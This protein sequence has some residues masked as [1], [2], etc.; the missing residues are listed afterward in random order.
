MQLYGTMF[1]IIMSSCSAEL[2]K[3]CAAIN[4][5]NSSYYQRFESFLQRIFANLPESHFQ[6]EELQV[7]LLPDIDR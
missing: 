3:H 7:N 2:F 6:F 1:Q 5:L 4:Y